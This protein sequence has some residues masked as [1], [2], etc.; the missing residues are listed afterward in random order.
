VKIKT[1]AS[2]YLFCDV[3]NTPANNSP[4]NTLYGAV[5]GI[6]DII[7]SG[8][9]LA[10]NARNQN[11]PPRNQANQSLPLIPNFHRA[12]MI[13]GLMPRKMEIIPYTTTST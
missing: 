4:I 6:D 8:T 11:K 3:S 5:S 1:K 12:K 10:S 9:N 2:V 13:A 7:I